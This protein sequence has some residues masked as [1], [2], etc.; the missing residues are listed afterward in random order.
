MYSPGS[1][2]RLQYENWL[3]CQTF[4]LPEFLQAVDSIGF[5]SHGAAAPSG[6]GRPHYRDFTITPRHNTLGMISLNE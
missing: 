5:C 2:F 3:S 6:P 4:D 1:G